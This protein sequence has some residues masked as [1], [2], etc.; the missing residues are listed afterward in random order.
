MIFSL[1]AETSGRVDGTDT[2][3]RYLPVVIGDPALFVLVV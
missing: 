2:I 3:K 1:I